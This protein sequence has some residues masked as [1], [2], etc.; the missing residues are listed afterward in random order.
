MKR[1][2]VAALLSVLLFT[3]AGCGSSA[4]EPRE[5]TAANLPTSAPPGMIAVK[6]VEP[7]AEGTA[8]YSEDGKL[9]GTIKKY[10]PKHEFPDKK[11]ESGVLLE[12]SPGVEEWVPKTAVDATFLIKQ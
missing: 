8:V 10:E 2:L 1:I 6:D 4:P 12:K 5:E 3:L 11:I 9:F 7:L